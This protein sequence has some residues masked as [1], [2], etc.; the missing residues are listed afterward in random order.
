MPHAILKESQRDRQIGCS[1]VRQLGAG[2]STELIP[3]SPPVIAAMA[4]IN[5]AHGAQ[6][7]IT[8]I[9]TDDDRDE[10]IYAWSQTG[11]PAAFGAVAVMVGRLR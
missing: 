6:I 2:A 5:V 8:A 11:G 1:L 9:G 10:I 7:T 3:N 4:P